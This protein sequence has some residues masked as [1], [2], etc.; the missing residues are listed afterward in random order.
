MSRPGDE[1]QVERERYL[2]TN[3]DTPV[4]YLRELT[5]SADGTVRRLAAGHPSCPPE[6]LQRAAEEPDDYELQVG[7]A[8]NVQAPGDVLRALAE[9]AVFDV[10]IAVANNVVTPPDVL[11]ALS[12]DDLPEVR[13]QVAANP[14]TPEDALN[15]M[16]FDLSLGAQV[17]LA[18]NPAAGA[19]ALDVLSRRNEPEVRRACAA[20][21]NIRPETLG[22]L[23]AREIREARNGTLTRTLIAARPDTPVDILAE[24]TLDLEVAVRSAVAANPQTPGSALR[25][26]ARNDVDQGVRDAAAQRVAAPTQSGAPPLI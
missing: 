18:Q 10:R 9:S 1:F 11:K 8:M 4:R 16:V 19:A 20:H 6:I 23:A 25:Y 26:L 3:P 24:L 15:T 2:A 21:D 17:A 22:L 7:A 14:S 12:A 5:R 13:F